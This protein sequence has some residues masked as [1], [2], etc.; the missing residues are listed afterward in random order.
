M[1]GA[2]ARLATVLHVG[3]CLK[4]ERQAQYK[5]LRGSNLT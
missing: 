5:M 1:I 4:K 2:A 3:K